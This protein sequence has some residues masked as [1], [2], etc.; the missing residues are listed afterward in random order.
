MKYP[1]NKQIFFSWYFKNQNKEQIS[2]FIAPYLL[3]LPNKD[4][5]FSLHD[6]LQSVSVIPTKLITGYTG[7]NKRVT[8]DQVELVE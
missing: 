8:V 1:V 5:S 6:I 4:V 7:K 2:A 3:S